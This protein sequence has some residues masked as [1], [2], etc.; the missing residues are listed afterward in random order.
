[1]RTICLQCTVCT[2]VCVQFL[3]TV[4]T[5]SHPS[6]L[7]TGKNLLRGAPEKKNITFNKTHMKK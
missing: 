7:C 5:H 2:T 6:K 4:R 3:F 1:M